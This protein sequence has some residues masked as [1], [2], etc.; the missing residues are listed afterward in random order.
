MI[1]LVM[2]TL[3]VMTRVTRYT[4]L[5][6]TVQLI[7]I[8][9]L[10]QVSSVIKQI[11]RLTEDGNVRKYRET[12]LAGYQDKLIKIFWTPT[13]VKPPARPLITGVMPALTVPTSSVQ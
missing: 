10:T 7:N 11:L 12:L 3:D 5:V 1:I 2:R 9:T 8:W 6:L 4:C 13:T